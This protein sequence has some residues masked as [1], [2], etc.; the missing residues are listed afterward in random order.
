[1]RYRC[2]QVTVRETVPDLRLTVLGDPGGEETLV[3]R[4]GA[5]PLDLGHDLV[6][7]DSLGEDESDSELDQGREEDLDLVEERDREDGSEAT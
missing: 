4:E 5:L 1:M 6:V 3:V 7:A 2:Q